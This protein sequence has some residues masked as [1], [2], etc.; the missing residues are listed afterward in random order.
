[1]GQ[2]LRIG[3]ADNG[4]TLQMQRGQHLQLVVPANPSTGYVW[5]ATGFAPVLAQQGEALWVANGSMPGSGGVE[6]WSFV[7]DKTGVTQ[8][9]LRYLRPW[10]AM[11]LR[12]LS[13]RVEV[14]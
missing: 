13:Y 1:A 8:L 11:P 5:Q 9:R 2:V 10:E 12:E 7:A 6:T 14:Y 4:L 3:E